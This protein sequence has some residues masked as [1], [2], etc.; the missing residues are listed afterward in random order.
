MV[1]EEA[2]PLIGGCRCGACQYVLD[3]VSI[4]ITYACHCLD[5][6]TMTGSAFA[7]HA[8]VPAQRFSIEGETIE[9]KHPN[10]QGKVTSQRFCAQCKTRIYSTNEGRPGAVIVRMGTLD[11]SVL[12]RPSVHLWVKRKQPWVSLPPDAEAFEEGMPKERAIAIIAANF[13]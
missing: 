3:Y 1:T 8:V 9:W 2:M 13:D 12:V 5:C 6:Q 10:S 4:P 7:E 11:D